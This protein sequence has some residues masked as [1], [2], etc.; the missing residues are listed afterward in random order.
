M[1]LALDIFQG[2]GIAL[3]VGIRPFL[4]ALAVGALAAGDVQ[5]DFKGTDFSFLQSTPFLLGMVVGAFVLAYAERRVGPQ[6]PIRRPFTLVVLGCGLAL[7]ALLFAGA[8][9]QDHHETWPGFIA[10]VACAAL[11]A[12]ATVPLLSRVRARLDAAAAAAVPL[13]GEGAGLAV[14]VLSVLAPPVGIIAAAL[15]AW[16]LFAGRR[17]DGQKYAGLRILR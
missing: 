11:G 5:I 2:V 4:P 15:L 12:A 10:G 13:Y 3:A 17:R 8:L 9:A 6:S 16:M 7:G 14:A 1:H